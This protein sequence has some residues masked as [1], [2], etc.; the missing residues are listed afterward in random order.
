MTGVEVETLASAPAD[1]PT[2]EP[3]GSLARD[4]LAVFFHPTSLFRELPRTNR[5]A[6]ALLLL[7]ALYGL[8]GL[9][10][11]TTGVLNYEIDVQTQTQISGLRQH[12]PAKDDAAKFTSSL[13]TIEKGSV[14]QKE[15]TRVLL[16]AG[17]PIQL[18][19]SVSVLSALLFLVV[20]LRGGKPNFQVLLGVTTFASYVAVPRLLMQL[21]QTA[22]LHVSRVET[23]AAAFCSRAEVGLANYL[24]LRRLDPFEAWYYVL[25]GLGVYHAGQLKRWSAIVTACVLA[26]LAAVL[27]VIGDLPQFADFGSVSF[28]N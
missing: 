19:L 21:A 9:G 8:Y 4:I 17:G 15:L 1:Q 28:G 6:S 20:A 16:L 26:A 11:Y 25:V 13:E 22:Q 10:L 27:H 12:P 2:A 5:V 23:S 7:M 24:L 18:C 14:F 3:T